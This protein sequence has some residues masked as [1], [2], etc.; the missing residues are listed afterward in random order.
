MAHRVKIKTL[1]R[2]TPLQRIFRREDKAAALGRSV[3]AWVGVF[4]GREG[5]RNFCV[6]LATGFAGTFCCAFGEMGYAKASYTCNNS[7]SWATAL[8]I[9]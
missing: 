2:V 8:A 3:G 6:S 7:G 5:V 1:M 4:F 9:L